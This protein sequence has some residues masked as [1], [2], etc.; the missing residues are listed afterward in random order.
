MWR[1]KK[2]DRLVGAAAELKVKKFLGRG[3]SGVT[4]LSN[5]IS[6]RLGTGM[7]RGQLV[8]IKM[9]TLKS[10]QTISQIETRLATLFHK[11]L[12]ERDAMNILRKLNCVAHI[13]DHGSY[14]KIL[15]DGSFSSGSIPMVVQ[16]YIVG[17][18]LDRYLAQR[19]STPHQGRHKKGRF[20]GLP[21][22]Q[23]FFYWTRHIVSVIGRVHQRQIIHGDIWENN[24]IVR[25]G[26]REPVLIDFGQ[27]AF[28]RDV[29]L[30]GQEI[31]SWMAPEG[32][33]TVA[34]D[35]YSLGGLLLYLAT[36]PFD[37]KTERFPKIDDI[38]QLKKA[39]VK[40][41]RRNNPRLYEANCGIADIIARCL[42]SDRHRRTP[43][44]ASLSQDIELFDP[45]PGASQVRPLIDQL[46][47]IERRNPLIGA[48]V[49]G[50]IMRLKDL[51]IDLRYGVVDLL[52]DHEN[53]VVSL[54]RVVSLLAK[55]D[56][57]LTI[58]TPAFWR[59]H[60]LGVQ[61]RFL[62]AN[63]QAVLQNGAEIKRLFLVTKRDL[64]REAGLRDIIA[65]QLGLQRD[66]RNRIGANCGIY[67]VRF[68]F[69]GEI[70]RRKLLSEGMNFG[71]LAKG[72][73]RI[74][75]AVDYADD[76]TIGGIQFRS[77][78]K[79]ARHHENQ[80]RSRFDRAYPLS[81]LW[82]RLSKSGEKKRLR[83]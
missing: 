10:A 50:A 49:Q 68:T 73:A 67:D 66:A 43:N 23:A 82:S 34:A 52:G 3:G 27:A 58:T 16:E 28:R 79:L 45:T 21:T 18:R 26:T 41:M 8:V 35:I 15:I 65:A 22:S 55:G 63:R 72:N 30:G 17:E 77:D 12:K 47:L 6:A 57:Y 4:Y 20:R 70:E 60:N 69:V 29:T 25:K 1:L 19:A 38:D 11:G 5:V 46:K 44:V 13:Y 39:I 7:K 76:G 32:G 78:A 75:L 40:R 83:R 74:L 64:V 51:L 37:A 31:G 24:V 36:G 61:G 56:K 42:R 14:R 33:P 2:G 80:F 54:T 9:P 48:L 81:E 71:V 53:I 62:S 59:E